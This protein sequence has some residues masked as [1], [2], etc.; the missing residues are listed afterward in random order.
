MKN[1]SETPK[2]ITVVIPTHRRGNMLR[3]ALQS[4]ARQ[5][6]TDLIEEIIVSENSFDLSSKKIVEEFSGLPIRYINQPKP[7]EAGKHFALLLS[8]VKTEWAAFLGDD[9]MWG[10]YHLE[11]GFRCLSL[12][13]DCVAYVG[14]DAYIRDEKT[15]AYSIRQHQLGVFK[16]PHA[17]DQTYIV[18]TAEDMTIACL[19]ETPLNMWSMIG[20]V[21]NLE[22]SFTAYSENNSGCDSDRYMF[23]L[24]SQQ[25]NIVIN[26]EITLF[27]RFHSASASTNMLRE[28]FS[29]HQKKA[30][31]YT[32]HIIEKCRENKIDLES[33]WTAKLNT[34]HPFERNSYW[35]AGIDGSKNIIRKSWP[36]TVQ[37]F[38][39]CERTN[40]FKKIIKYTTPPILLHIFHYIKS[41]ARR[42]K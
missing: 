20:R 35:D 36:E 2:K 32:K 38:F 19:T 29:F 9:D 18:A 4:V 21:K 1:E 24:L 14:W 34:L 30:E 5:S 7:T 33:A 42:A 31:E 11:E 41:Y 8:E 40:N 37:K 26:R 16:I 10:R 15:P 23:W 3:S 22:A 28:N 27:Y 6:R 13:P 39:G 25:G 12:E 17:S